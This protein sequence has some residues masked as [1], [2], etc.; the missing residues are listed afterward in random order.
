MYLEI[1]NEFTLETE[2]QESL[3]QELVTVLVEMVKR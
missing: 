3:F 1:N 2:T